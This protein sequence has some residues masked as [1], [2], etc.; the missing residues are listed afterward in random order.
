MASWGL[1]NQHHQTK[2]R[3]QDRSN[4][5]AAGRVI[6]DHEI[7]RKEEP[8][9]SNM[10]HLLLKT[11]EQVTLELRAERSLVHQPL[12]PPQRVDVTGVKSQG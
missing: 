9:L 10:Y 7:L 1:L 4:G 12:R 6:P 8:F 3:S 2:P 5:G 11:Q